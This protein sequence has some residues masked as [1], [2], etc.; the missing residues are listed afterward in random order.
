MYKALNLYIG[1]SDEECPV[2]L[3]S[4]V[5]RTA[6][7]GESMALTVQRAALP[8]F[9]FPNFGTLLVGECFFRV[10]YGSEPS[11]NIT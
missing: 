2:Y 8:L 4:G 7:S 6:D 5:D 11:L 1:R 3:P 9:S 10:N